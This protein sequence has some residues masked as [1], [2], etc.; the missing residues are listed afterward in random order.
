MWQ[1]NVMTVGSCI[2]FVHIGWS[3][4]LFFGG[5]SISIKFDIFVMRCLKSDQKRIC[6]IREN[7]N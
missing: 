7:N 3:S 6:F 1:L 5:V 2:L 4:E